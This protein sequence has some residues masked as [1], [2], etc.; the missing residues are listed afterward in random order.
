MKFRSTLIL[1]S[2]TL[3]TAALALQGVK[4][5]AVKARMDAMGVIGDNTQVLGHMAKGATPFD[6]ARARAAAA[7]IAHHAATTPALF[8]AREDDPKSEAMPAIWDNFNDFAIKAMAL[9]TAAESA[10]HG[11]ATPQDL[12]AAL[13]EIGAACKSCHQTYRE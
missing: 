5:P 7:A 6:A 1:A 3:A 8:E 2:L 11:V 9:Q 4:N 12:R 10:A 13:G